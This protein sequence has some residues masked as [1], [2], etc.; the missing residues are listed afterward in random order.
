MKSASSSSSAS[1]Y[2][3]EY[4]QTNENQNNNSNL[5]DTD[6][7]RIIAHWLTIEY[8]ALS[9]MYKNNNSQLARL[10]LISSNLIG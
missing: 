3:S 8:Q 7:R 4:Q 5:N 6:A 9:K 10:K 2:H 1:L